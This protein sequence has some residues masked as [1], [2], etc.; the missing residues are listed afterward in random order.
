MTITANL[1]DNAGF[2][3]DDRPLGSAAIVSYSPFVQACKAFPEAR[4][5]CHLCLFEAKRPIFL[6][7]RP[8]LLAK[9]T[10]RQVHEGVGGEALWDLGHED[11][12]RPSQVGLLGSGRAFSPGQSRRPKVPDQ[13]GEKTRVGQSLDPLGPETRAYRLLHV[14]APNR[15]RYGQVSQRLRKR[16][17]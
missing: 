14:T 9:H 17:G 2:F 15:V 16:S 4:S 11:R 5:M 10:I 1:C 7:K 12:Q 6:A 8:T 13:T 3:G